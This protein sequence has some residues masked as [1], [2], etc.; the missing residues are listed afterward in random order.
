MRGL[1]GV[2]G[3]ALRPGDVNKRTVADLVG[4]CCHGADLRQLRRGIEEAFVPAWN[5]VVRFNSENVILLGSSHD[6]V[7][8]A[9]LKRVGRDAD[10]VGPVL[11]V[12]IVRRSTGSG[13]CS[14]DDEYQKKHDS[15][16][17]FAYGGQ[18]S[19]R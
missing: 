3:N 9:S 5:I 6:L 7:R 11:V 18:M 15:T 1:A 2:G 10:V 12:R 13:A 19:L 14:N 17:T 16:R 4:L 8:I